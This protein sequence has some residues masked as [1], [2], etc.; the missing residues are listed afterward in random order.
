MP[1]K[2]RDRARVVQVPV[3]KRLELGPEHVAL[4]L[5]E[6]ELLDALRDRLPVEARQLV[7]EK[8]GSCGSG[9][10]SSTPSTNWSQP[11]SAIASRS[12]IGPERRSSPANQLEICASSPSS[13]P[14][15]ERVISAQTCGWCQCTH[16]PPSS[17]SV[18]FQRCV[19]VRPPS[20]S[21]ASR[22]SVEAPPRVASRAAVT[23]ANP[24][25]MTT[26]S[27]TEAESTRPGLPPEKAG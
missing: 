19:Q 23:P 7:A 26:T 11:R 5:V 15:P 14:S 21:R 8:S 4:L 2:H 24:P 13:T 22:R 3:R 16:P 10:A 20:R 18:S 25:P 1:A 12:V 6:V 17:T 27:Y 9:S